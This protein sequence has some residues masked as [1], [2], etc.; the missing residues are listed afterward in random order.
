MELETVLSSA[1][2]YITIELI[3]GRHAIITGLFKAIKS[4]TVVI[5]LNQDKSRGRK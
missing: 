3:R 4:V 5:V 2:V 1:G